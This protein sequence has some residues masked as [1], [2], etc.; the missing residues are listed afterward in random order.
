MWANRTN[1]RGYYKICEQSE[2]TAEDIIKYVSNQN[3]LCRGYYKICEQTEQTED[4]IKYVSNQNKL[5]RIL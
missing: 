5:Q 4:V 2:Q 3:K 1:C